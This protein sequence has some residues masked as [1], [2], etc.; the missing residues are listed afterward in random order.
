MENVCFL[1]GKNQD[2]FQELSK[3]GENMC[4]LK[5]DACGVE[6]KKRGNFPKTL[7]EP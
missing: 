5:G 4:S 7:M 2:C 6:L 1:F 3:E